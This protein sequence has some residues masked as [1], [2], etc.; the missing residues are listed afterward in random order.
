VSIAGVGSFGTLSGSPTRRTN[1]L[2]QLVD[3]LSHQAGPHALR[4]GIDFV[5][6]D[7]A[8]TYPRSFR[9]NYTF[10]SLA[11]FLTGT[12]SGFTQTFG[13]PVVAQTNPNVGMYAQDEWSV[14]SGLTLNLGIRYDLQ[15][16]HT[17]HTDTNNISPRLGFAWS[18]SGSQRLLVRGGAGLF[19]DRVPLRAVA[20]AVLSAGNTTDLD[21]LHQ[22]AVAG[23]IPTQDGAPAFPNIL[24]ARIL[25][26]TL[27]DFTTM[28]RDLHNAYSKQA[29]VEVE[30]SVGQGRTLN[31]GYQYVGGNNLLMSVNQNV[32]ACVA[33]GTN[34]GCRPNG[35][36]RNNNQYSSVAQSNYHGLHLSF[37]QRP[38]TWSSVRLTYTLSTSMNDVGEAFFSAPIDPTNIMR[39]WARSDDDQ[40]HRLVVN[41]TLN[42]SMAA[43]A[44]VW[45]RITHGFQ[46]SGLLQAYS[47][48]PFNIT[49]GVTSLQGTTG[50]PL[51]HGGTTAANFD[52]RSVEFISRNAGVGSDFFTLNLRLNRAFRITNGIKLEGMVEAFNITN[53]VNNLTRNTNFGNGSYPADPVSTFNQITA[54]GD[55]RTFQF[56]ARLTF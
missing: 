54:V 31:L 5:F 18:P 39:D 26:T 36:Y 56:G 9:G 43:A 48:L 51:T 6:N 40:R 20:N 13:D 8:I 15:F 34:N 25:T 3:N 42:T 45:Q 33:A 53:R 37:V 35:S 10:S 52:V 47:A 19:F 7:D 22:P 44:N 27:V 41:G 38:A 23:L 30:R 16:L 2:Y 55:P 24:P 46:L 49:S 32:P 21:K 12:Y 11:N 4:A 14:G 29:S 17:I 50:R 28:N 1:R